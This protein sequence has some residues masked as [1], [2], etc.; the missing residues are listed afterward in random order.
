MTIL[1]DERTVASGTTCKAAP[2]PQLPAVDAA[3]EFYLYG[4][5][6]MA[7]RKWVF[8]GSSYPSVY[9]CVQAPSQ[10]AGLVEWA[11]QELTRLRQLPKAWDGHRA[12]PITQEALYGAAWVLSTVLNEHS[13]RPQV[14]PLPDGGIQIEWYA[15]GEEIEIEIDS[16]G[17]AHVL[18]ESAKGDTLAEGS[19]DPQSPNVT[20]TVI[21]KIVADFSDR[22][23]AAIGQGAADDC[24]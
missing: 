11:V 23:S 16:A 15:D 4:A 22:V 24:R 20:I 21:T 12:R 6:G 2:P 17:E 14:F 5:H 7:T 19:F 1:D 3:R 10:R 18:A 8:Q 9:F 13:R